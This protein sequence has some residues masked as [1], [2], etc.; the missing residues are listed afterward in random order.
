MLNQKQSGMK[1]IFKTPFRL[2]LLFFWF[3]SPLFTQAQAPAF[4]TTPTLSVAY[5]YAYNYSVVATMEGS[6]PTTLTAP[7]LPAWLSFSGLGQ[8]QATLIGNIPSG[9]TVAGVAGDDNGNI[10]AITVDGTS[11]Y[12]IASDG[13]TTLWRTG[14]TCL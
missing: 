7:T 1:T 12:K 14:L 11:I 13:T 3:S 6:L 10:Y 5:N 2:I 8:S 4:T 9:I